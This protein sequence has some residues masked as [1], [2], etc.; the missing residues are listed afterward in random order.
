MPDS[1]LEAAHSYV[2]RGI[3][4]VPLPRGSK[5]PIIPGWQHLRLTEEELSEHF[6]PGDNIGLLLG[7]P[8]SGLVDVDLDAPEALIVADA[9]LPPTGGSRSPRQAPIS[10]ILQGN[11]ASQDAATYRSRH[12]VPG[13]NPE[14]RRPDDGTPERPPVGRA[15]ELGARR[16]ARIH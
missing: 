7:E 10:S 4:V 13:R 12:H 9:F 16:R 5:K 11:G 3:R 1:T 14:H 6:G 2:R 15:P 8:S